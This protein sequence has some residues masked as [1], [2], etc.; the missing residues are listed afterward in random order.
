[1]FEE[2]E[3]STFS[4]WLSELLWGFPGAE[5]FHL[6]ML[7]SFFGGIVMLDLRLLGINRFISSQL[8]MRH[9]LRC[10]WWAFAGVILSGGLLFLF[11]PLEYS[12]NPA[13]KI[14]LCLMGLGGINA[15][16]MHKFLMNNIEEWDLNTLPPLWVRLSA[17]VSIGIWTGVLACGRLI[18]YYYSFGSY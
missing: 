12:N 17:L 9:I 11:M 14:K 18:A 15:F 3:N 1:M 4:I 7:C 6:A 5:V 16:I 10:T 8:L 13:F 2:L